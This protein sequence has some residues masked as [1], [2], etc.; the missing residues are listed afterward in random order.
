[1]RRGSPRQTTT[2]NYV[3]P[4]QGAFIVDHPSEG[5]RRAAQ[6]LDLGFADGT[7]FDAVINDV[8]SSCMLNERWS[9]GQLNNS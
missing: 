9:A 1:M 8:R 6:V 5:V 3:I 7:D 4:A 2:L